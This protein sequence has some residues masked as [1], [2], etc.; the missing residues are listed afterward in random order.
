MVKSY[1]L[2]LGIPLRSVYVEAY[3]GVLPWDLDGTPENRKHNSG[4]RNL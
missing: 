1:F 2:N 4:H 3:R